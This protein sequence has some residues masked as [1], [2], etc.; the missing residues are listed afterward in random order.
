MRNYLLDVW[1][2]IDPIY[3]TCSRLHSVSENDQKN[4]NNTLFRVRLT[5]YLGNDVVLQDGT[6]I[7]KHDLLLKIHL[8]NVKILNE[9]RKTDNQ[10]KKA[11]YIYH[12]IKRGLPMLANY[13]SLY[14]KSNEIK[15]IIGITSLS[16]GANKLGFEVFDIKNTYYRT[17][18]KYAISP[19][20]FIANTSIK[21]PVYLLMSK[22]KL[23]NTYHFSRI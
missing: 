21:A 20:N 22:N 4:S 8:H 16:Q 7:H 1:N 23:I 14:E 13:I 2:I 5:N 9:L 6:I 3:Y 10:F 17:Y 18:K 19:M 15:G 12:E 11:L